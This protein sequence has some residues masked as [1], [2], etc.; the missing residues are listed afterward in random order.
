MLLPHFSK[1]QA[2]PPEL[3][4]TALPVLPTPQQLAESLR[5]SSRSRNVV[6]DLGFSA[7]AVA[8]ESCWTLAVGSAF[9]CPGL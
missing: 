9:F 3:V 4:W 1:F 5:M 6:G 2:A 8:L 7:L